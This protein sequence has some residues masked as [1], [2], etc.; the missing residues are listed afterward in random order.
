[1]FEA[2]LFD[3]DGILVDTECLFVQ[4]CQEVLQEMYGELCDLKTYQQYGYTLGIG[5]TGWLLE[6]GY[7]KE[8]I[9]AY[10]KQRDRRYEEFLSKGISPLKGVR[11]VLEFLQKMKYQERL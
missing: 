4:A 7:T 9:A 2:V 5:T 8:D 3:N 11:D 6:K 10:R 1:M